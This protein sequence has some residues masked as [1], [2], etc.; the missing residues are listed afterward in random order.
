[1]KESVHKRYDESIMNA[2]RKLRELSAA[3]D[4]YYGCEREATDDTEPASKNNPDQPRDPQ[5][6]WATGGGN[7]G[8]GDNNNSQSDHSQEGPKPAKDF[9]TS[10]RGVSFIVGFEQ[11]RPRAYR[12]E[13]GKPTIGYG[14][15]LQEGEEFPNGIS[16]DEALELLAQDLETAETPIKR[17]VTVNLTQYQFDALTSLVF[18]IGGGNF[19]DSTLSRLLNHGNYNRAADQFLLWNNR[20]DNGVLVPSAGLTN[21]RKLERNLFLHGKYE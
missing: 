8:A 2:Q 9:I 14:H 5:G 3:L 12:D 15:L 6:R 21:R 17:K 18:N 20:R 1:M 13:G 7:S 11:F 19:K 10:G 4:R 16:K